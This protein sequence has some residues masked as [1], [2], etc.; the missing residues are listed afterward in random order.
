LATGGGRRGDCRGEEGK[1]QGRV[2]V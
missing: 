1:V 2:L